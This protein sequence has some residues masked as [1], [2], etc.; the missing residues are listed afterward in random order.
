MYFEIEDYRPDITPVGS[1]ISWREGV[2]LSI[3]AHLLFIII[4]LVFPKLFSSDA[5]AR[6]RALLARQQ[7]AEKR[8]PARFVFVAPRLDQPA[9]RPPQRAEPSDQDRI[10]RAPQRAPRPT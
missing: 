1:A 8:E 9:P 2:L 7:Q 6:A 5:N 3:I 10:A 4:L